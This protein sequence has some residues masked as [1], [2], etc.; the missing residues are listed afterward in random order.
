MVF[1]LVM[2]IKD[3]SCEI[4]I[5]IN[6]LAA[7][8]LLEQTSGTSLLDIDTFGIAH[9]EPS[10]LLTDNLL[11]CKLFQIFRIWKTILR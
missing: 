5:A 11:R 1:Q 10:E 2:D 3:C 9:K 4:A 6:L 8:G 7:K